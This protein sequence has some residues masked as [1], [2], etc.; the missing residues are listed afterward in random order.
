MTVRIGTCGWD[1]AHWSEV[2]YPADL[3]RA[4]RLEFAAR[5]FD[6]LEIDTSFYRLPETKTLRQWRESTPD[7]FVFAF[8]ASRTITHMKKLKDAGDALQTML[9]RA[10]TLEEKLGPILFQLPPHWHVN[11]DRLAGFLGLLP[12]DL[13]FAVEFRDHSWFRRDVHEL[14]RE[15]GVASCIYDLGGERSPSDVTADMVYLRLHGPGTPYQGSYSRT[16]LTALAEEIHG[17]RRAG[18]DVYCYFDN[19]EQGYAAINAAELRD[20]VI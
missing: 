1:Y 7:G 2:F 18:H 3:P 14:L 16:A 19:D 10:R 8:K 15:R 4:K 20:M 12:D 13:A 5:S 17:W 11:A 6:S 9:D